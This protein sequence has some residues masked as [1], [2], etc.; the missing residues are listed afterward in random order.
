LREAEN[1]LRDLEAAVA[2]VTFEAGP[3]AEAYL[4]ETALPWPLLLDRERTLYHAYGMLHA[5][6]WDLYGPSSLWLYLKL[7]SKGRRLRRPGSDVHQRGGDVLIDPVGTVRL[8]HVGSGPADRPSVASI[9]DRV[10][11]GAA[12]S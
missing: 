1:E 4:E 3:L 12:P 5:R 10:R 11:H 6:N 7:L 8:H 9:L 2:I